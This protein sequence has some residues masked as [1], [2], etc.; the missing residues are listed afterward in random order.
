[1]M[2]LAAFLSLVAGQEAPFDLNR[3]KPPDF[4]L[5]APESPADD[6]AKAPP[7]RPQQDPLEGK[8]E[9]P[10]VPPDDG[11]RPASEWNLELLP[12]K[13]LYPPYLADPRMART[14]TRVQFPI[15][16][17]DNIKI[18]NDLGGYRALARWTNP[19]DP[20]EEG[21]LYVEAGVFTRFDI[22]EQWDMDA[23]DYRF[24]FPFIYRL[25]NVAM[26]FEI[27][28]VTSHLGDE[29]IGRENAHRDSYHLEEAAWGVSWDLTPAWRTYAEAGVGVYTGTATQSGRVQAG[30]E[31][32]GPPV[33][34]RIC[35]FAALDLQSRNE[36]DW[37]VNSAWMTGLM[38]KTKTGG[39]GLRVLGEYYRGH[40]QQT[41]FKSDREQYWSLGLAT[42]F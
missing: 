10:A 26:K 11:L 37:D 29:Y 7:P 1:M 18:E 16:H 27:Y 14:A 6:D 24:G 19:H 32:I 17:D 22:Q 35:P 33:V 23:A 30:T 31:W 39:N 8:Q 25:G 40:D 12:D 42:D 4:G 2:C 41:Q 36:I 38:V 13:H 34:G 3:E 5:T 21:M 20:R 28:H 9:P 15:K